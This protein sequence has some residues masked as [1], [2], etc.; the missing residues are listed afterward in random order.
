MDNSSYA[1]KYK[2]VLGTDITNVGRSPAYNPEYPSFLNI[3]R[4]VDIVPLPPPADD[5]D[6]DDI[7]RSGVDSIPT[8]QSIKPLLST[9]VPLYIDMKRY[10]TTEYKKRCAKSKNVKVDVTYHPLHGSTFIPR[11]D[12]GDI[13]AC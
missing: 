4:S 5:D 11:N 13:V 9:N 6:D 2:T 3:F 8:T 1:V 10:Y 12:T 7:E